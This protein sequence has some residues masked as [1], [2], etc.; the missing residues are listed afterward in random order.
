MRIWNVQETK[1]FFCW[2][3][4]SPNTSTIN[5]PLQILNPPF[6]LHYWLMFANTRLLY[7]GVFFSHTL[8]RRLYC[9]SDFFLSWSLKS[10]EAYADKMYHLFVLRIIPL[11]IFCNK[12]NKSHWRIYSW[13]SLDFDVMHGD[14][15]RNVKSS[16]KY[17]LIKRKKNY[18]SWGSRKICLCRIESL[19][20]SVQLDILDS[21]DEMCDKY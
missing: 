4:K 21:L 1:N 3:T 14:Q 17:K 19:P 7:Y 9:K 16:I 10:S 5:I 20:E 11:N 15:W 18:C 8:W 13:Y 12:R 2:W 6:F